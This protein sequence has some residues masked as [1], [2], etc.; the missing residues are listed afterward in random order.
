MNDGVHP[1]DLIHLV[2]NGTGLRGAR[3]IANDDSCRLRCEIRE[4]LLGAF[5]RARVQHDLMTFTH[6]RDRRPAT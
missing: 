4:R 1:A 6:E 5:L 2:R 3:E